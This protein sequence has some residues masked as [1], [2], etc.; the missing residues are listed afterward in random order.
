MHGHC[1]CSMDRVA[2]LL[3][4]CVVHWCG[5]SRSQVARAHGC[6]NAAGYLAM[7]EVE[8]S[9]EAS[10]TSLLTMSAMVPSGLDLVA[11]GAMV[12]AQVLLEV[13]EEPQA[14]ET[15]QN[16]EVP[17]SRKPLDGELL[18]ERRRELPLPGKP[19]D[20]ELLSK[21]PCIHERRIGLPV[22]SR[23]DSYRTGDSL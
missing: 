6:S 2:A 9:H 23:V 12:E 7:A 13:Q 18:Y 17:L 1:A 10:A 14:P 20:G 4:L 22:L 5:I 8:E 21:I 11:R 3:A 15:P 19:L 16:R